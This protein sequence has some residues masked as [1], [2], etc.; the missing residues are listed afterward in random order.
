MQSN[1][2][3]AYESENALVHGNPFDEDHD[4]ACDL[5]IFDDR[6]NE[7]DGFVDIA[8]TLGFRC[9]VIDRLVLIGDY[10]KALRSGKVLRPKLMAVDLSWDFLNPNFELL[11]RED[12]VVPKE[13]HL[14]G[15]V[16]LSEVLTHSAEMKDVPALMLSSYL[17]EYDEA[18]RAG[19]AKMR[20]RG[21]H[22]STLA[23]S[24]L[25]DAG[26]LERV[27]TVLA[28][29][30]IDLRPVNFVEPGTKPDV[31]DGVID[32]SLGVLANSIEIEAAELR[33]NW[34]EAVETTKLSDEQA[35]DFVRLAF[36]VLLAIKTIYSGPAYEQ[37]LDD[38]GA[39]VPGVI[40]R[41]AVAQGHFR[42]LRLLADELE[43][44]VGGPL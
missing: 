35:F 26:G 13:E 12:V 33:A 17:S 42:S 15:L 24:Q 10:L 5:V 37:T 19:L 29:L 11:G 21:I 41:D 20:A 44:R 1:G 7:V 40:V 27:A 6:P 22:V 4:T 32:R 9:Q 23:K 28:G 16:M 38:L 18:Y 3:E 31:P 25:R 36:K 34:K 8:T 30:D 39:V 2:V 43:M 14:R